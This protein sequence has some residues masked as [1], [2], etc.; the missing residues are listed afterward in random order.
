MWVILCVSYRY[1]DYEFISDN[2]ISWSAGLHNRYT[3][4]SLRGVILDIH[5]LSQTDFLVCTFSSQVG[6]PHPRRS[7]KWGVCEGTTGC[8]WLK[9][10]KINI[11]IYIYIHTH[12][13]IYIIFMNITNSNRLNKLWPRDLWNMFRGCNAIQ[14]NIINVQFILL[15]MSNMGLGGSQGYWYPQ[16]S[17]NYTFFNSIPQFF[18]FT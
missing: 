1:T 6:V 14:C 12:T 3:E 17:A 18:F 7:Q 13:Q 11:Y 4:N 9:Q 5:F 15:I 8:P 2:S 10:Q 16:Y